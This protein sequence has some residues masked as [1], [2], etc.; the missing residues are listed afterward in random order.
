MGF[1]KQI[2]QDKME[3]KLLQDQTFHEV[4]ELRYLQKKTE[5]EEKEQKLQHKE[6]YLMEKER[7]L[8]HKETEQE[9]NILDNTHNIIT[10]TGTRPKCNSSDYQLEDSTL[11]IE[12]REE[13]YRHF[14]ITE[15]EVDR[16]WEKLL[17]LLK[18]KKEHSS[19]RKCAA[20]KT[21][22]PSPNNSESLEDAT[23]NITKEGE[24]QEPVGGR[25]VDTE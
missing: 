19:R 1:Q 12:S 22:K 2:Q 24:S 5:Q 8:L 13:Q 25:W 21:L 11:K 3:Q 18:N 9:V 17:S 16:E 7:H 15:E 14:K 10:Q 20:Y 23:G 4:K 6:A